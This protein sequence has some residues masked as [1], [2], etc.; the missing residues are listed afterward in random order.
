ML[1]GKNSHLR[2]AF[3]VVG[4]SKG[5]READSDVQKIAECLIE[6]RRDD[7]IILFIPSHDKSRPQKKLMDQDQWADVGLKLFSKLYGGATAFVALRGVW[8][9][10]DGTDLF[11]EPIMIQSLARREDAESEEKL[12]QLVEFA[13]RLCKATSQARVGIV[14][15]DVIHYIKAH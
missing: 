11:D 8:R 2:E 4:K 9:D 1:L 13:R 7:T 15:N 10:A 5:E 12:L 6:G 14:F 3:S